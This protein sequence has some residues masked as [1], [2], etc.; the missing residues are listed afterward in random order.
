MFSST[1][2]YLDRWGSFGAGAGQFSSPSGIA[3][4]ASGNVY[5]ADTGNNRIEMFDPSHALQ[6]STGSLG[7]SGGQF[8]SPKGLTLDAAGHVWVADSGNNRIQEFDAAGNFM[9]TWG[10]LGTGNGKLTTPMD[11]EFG[12]DGLVYVSDKGNNRVEIFTAG[13]T[14]LSVLGSLGLDTGQFSAPVGLAIDPTSAA[15]RLLVADS[16]NHRVE[17]F[18]DSNGP[19]TTLQTFPASST[20]L[21]TAD[22][23]F[24][25][26]DVNA[27][28]ECK[29]DG[30]VTWDA[31]CNGSP[32]GSASYGGLTEGTHQFIVRARD[33]ANNPGN[34]T[35]YSWSIDLTA[36]TVSI[37][38]GPAEGQTNNNT[39]PSFQFGAD[40]PVLGF[41][42]SLDGGPYASC[43]SG[44]QFPV[45]GGAHTF[46]VRAT[47][48]AGNT[49]VSPTRHWTTDT[50]PPTVNITSG[51]SG[52]TGPNDRDDPVRLTV[53]RR[54]H[55]PV[56]SR[57]RG[58]LAACTSPWTYPSPPLPA[59]QH[60]FKVIATDSHGNSSAAAQ[61][62]WTVDTSTHRPDALIA[63]G[64]L[65]RR[66][67][68]LQRDGCGG[69]E[70]PQDEGR[71][72]RQVQRSRSRTTA[73]TWIRSTVV[74]PG[75]GNGYTVSYFDGSTN[76]TTAVKAGTC[77]FS[78]DHGQTHVITVKVKVGSSAAASKSILVK[79]TSGHD[80]SKV[81]A[82]KGV[83]KR[84]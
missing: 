31:T 72:D 62:K 34:P 38:G 45:G 56:R 53:R 23:T 80:P 65:L 26:N 58:L 30:A 3:V 1:G 75:S 48:I 12:A 63:T 50:T 2:T 10:T 79:V 83:V 29:L 35:T 55:V 74:G 67:R 59:G 19:D 15:T 68:C 81:D 5:V 28:F 69:V 27:T 18:I 32:A 20:K 71:S 4:D 73:T 17:T 51:P 9:L 77:T 33:A 70:D 24:T 25:A 64:I 7:S 61:R 52:L 11:V 6:W 49:G 57:R 66:R 41:S 47:D 42:C 8:K 76:I 36:P 84:A 54:R 44:N 21:A 40:E 16:L 43:S 22:F 60:T 14:F 46:A 37:T 78:L 39:N 13:G 82:V